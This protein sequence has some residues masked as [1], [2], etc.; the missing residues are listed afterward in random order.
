MN[1]S[2]KNFTV[3]HSGK[4]DSR[5]KV[6]RVKDI[7][8]KQNESTFWNL[9][10]ATNL[11]PQLW[12]LACPRQSSFTR[13]A[14]RDSWALYSSLPVGLNH[15][16]LFS[17]ARVESFWE[18][19]IYPW[20]ENSPRRAVLH[21]GLKTGQRASRDQCAFTAL[22][23][24]TNCWSHNPMWHVYVPK[25]ERKTPLSTSFRVKFTLLVFCVLHPIKRT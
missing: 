22:G 4:I 7:W 1:K 20:G 2:D 23:C 18:G 15:G 5:K 9:V 14:G 10:T 25:K 13:S 8:N 24:W 3:K 16:E 21:S 6:T 19:Q 17:G 11:G 12:F